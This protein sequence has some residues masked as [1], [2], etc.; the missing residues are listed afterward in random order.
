VPSLQDGEDLYEKCRTDES[1]G[2]VSGVCV[3]YIEAIADAMG[4][5]PVRNYRACIP[6][7]TQAWQLRP[8]VVR[9]LALHPDIRYLGADELVPRAYSEAFPCK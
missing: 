9:F 1:P 6:D 7:G 4:V 3:G 2:I 5:Y 8:V